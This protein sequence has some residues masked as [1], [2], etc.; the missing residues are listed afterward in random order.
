[1]PTYLD[2]AVVRIQPYLA[3]TPDLSLRRGASWMITKATSDEAVDTW[4]GGPGLGGIA[5]NPEAGHA[6]GVVNLTVADGT[7]AGHATRLLRHL[8]QAIPGADLQASWGHAASYMEFRTS[9]PP[10][11]RMLRALPPVADF[12]L[13]ETCRFCRADARGS[14]SD[15]CTDCAA[16]AAAAGHRRAKPR[17]SGQEPAAAAVDAL[18]TERLVSD[19]VGRARGR[20]GR[21]GWGTWGLWGPGGV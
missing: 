15:M 2:A 8:R 9:P 17:S 4:I 6:D 20:G 18:G 5:R 12:P 3:R 19:A 13:A 21:P 11:E 14:A 16:R 1:M 7:A 10:D